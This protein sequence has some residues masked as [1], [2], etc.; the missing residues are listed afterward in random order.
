MFSQTAS[1]L[2]ADSMSHGTAREP[3][4]TGLSAGRPPVVGY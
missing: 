4:A 1:M 2:G 3:T